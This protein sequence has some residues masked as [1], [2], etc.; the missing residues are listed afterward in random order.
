M[1]LARR[2]W[3]ELGGEGGLPDDFIVRYERYS[4]PGNVHELRVAVEAAIE[5][6]GEVHDSALRLSARVVDK[7]ALVSVL[8]RDLPLGDAR[9]VILAEFER[10]YVERA[11]RRAG[12]NTVRAAAASGIA[13]RY[14]HALRMRHDP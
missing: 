3:I 8:E 6:H 5:H 12:G 11:L 14:F 13:R 9:N 4:W 7:N 2:F 10:R 1:L